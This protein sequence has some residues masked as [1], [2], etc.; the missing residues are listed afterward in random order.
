MTY[1]E[2]LA[3]LQELPPERLEDDVSVYLSLT[4][5]IIPVETSFVMEDSCPLSAVLDPGHFCLQVDF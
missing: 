5:E 4:E 2:L 3:K 1:R